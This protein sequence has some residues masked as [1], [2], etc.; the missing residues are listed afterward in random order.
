MTSEAEPLAQ[1]LHDRAPGLVRPGFVAGASANDPTTVGSLAA[2]GASTVYGLAWLVVAILPMLAVT[3]V[4]AASVGAATRTSVQGAIVRRY[5]ITAGLISL[6]AIVA[7]NLFTLVADIEAGCQALSLLFG[8]PYQVFVLPFAAAIACLLLTHSYGRIA[9]WLMFV[10]I[11]FVAY[12][13]SA[14]LAHV[15]WL[16][17]A[18]HTLVPHFEFSGIYMVGALALIGTTITSYEYLWESIEVAQTRR[19]PSRLGPLKLDAVLGVLAAGAGFLFVLVASGATL[20]AHHLPIETVGDAA[21]ALTPFAGPA[22][23]ALFGI[24]LFGSALLTVPILAAS[25]AYAVAHTFGSNATLDA[26]IRDAMPFYIVIL[27]ALLIGAGASLL[28]LPPIRLLVWASI[29]AGL[30][31]P[32]TLVLMNLVARSK[33]AMGAYRIGLPLSIAGWTVTAIIVL[34]CAAYLALSSRA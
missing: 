14:V 27:A 8:I 25:T 11:L 22:A 7:V 34:T 15:D 16:D 31:T 33:R 26:N 13:G 2:V 9:T 20:G 12:A 24:G 21:R 18:R 6:A 17:V 19:S 1:P 29:A 23:G 5:G 10:P 3:Q 32:I 28:G 4:I 30:G